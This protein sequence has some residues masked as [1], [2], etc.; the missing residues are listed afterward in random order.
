VSSF[1]ILRETL[2]PLLNLSQMA[3]S[4]SLVFPIRAQ[5]VATLIQKKN[6]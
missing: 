1:F 3:A 4:L 5:A 2:S 6:V